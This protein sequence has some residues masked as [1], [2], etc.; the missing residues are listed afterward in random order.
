MNFT[1]DFDEAF[2]LVESHF[3]DP[4]LLL[5]MP[6]DQIQDFYM[7]IMLCRYASEPHLFL[8]EV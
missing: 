6:D 3:D 5:D 1:I 8:D 7:Q 4:K 2:A